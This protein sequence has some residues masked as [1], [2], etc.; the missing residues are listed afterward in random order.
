MQEFLQV[1]LQLVEVD[2]GDEA[3]ARFGQAVSGQL[4]NLVVDEAEDPV[5]QRQHVLRRVRLDEITQTLLHL[6]FGLNVTDRQR[7]F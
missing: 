1:L 5:G 2:G 7:R 6:S 4:C 3:F